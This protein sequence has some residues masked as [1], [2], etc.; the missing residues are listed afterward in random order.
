MIPAGLPCWRGFALRCLQQRS[1][2]LLG[3]LWGRWR[4]SIFLL[5]PGYHGAGTGFVG[6]LIPFVAFVTWTITLAI[7]LHVS[8]NTAY[9]VM[10]PKLFPSLAGTPLIGLSLYSV[11]VVVALLIIAATQGVP[12]ALALLRRR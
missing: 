12:F 2:P 4:L 10:L 6:I 7:L 8:I 3:V 11:W 1:G 9:F 5:S